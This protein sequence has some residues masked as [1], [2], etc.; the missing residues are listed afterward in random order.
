MHQFHTKSH[1][2]TDGKIILPKVPF[3]PGEEVDIYISSKSDAKNKNKKYPLHGT[4]V[5]YNN[6][7]MPVDEHEWEA[8]K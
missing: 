4:S 5:K 7:F 1:V 2:S 8:E 3:N 6:P